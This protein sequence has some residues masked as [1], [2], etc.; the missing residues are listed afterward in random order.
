MAHT[1]DPTL[2][3]VQ[4]KHEKFYHDIMASAVLNKLQDREIV[5]IL[6]LTLGR[7]I[8]TAAI[9]GTKVDRDTL[10]DTALHNMNLGNGEADKFINA[11]N[12]PN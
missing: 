1:D 2:I 4:V 10:L 8:G 9:K 3:T 6:A 11:L 7:F 12:K 5:A